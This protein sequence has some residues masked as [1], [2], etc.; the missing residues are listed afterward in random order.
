MTLDTD[1]L[2][3]GAG[4][5]GLSAACVLRKAGVDV[6]V[7]DAH[8]EGANTSRAAV[9]HART[10]EVLE[11]IDMSDELIREGLVVPEFTV[12]EKNRTLVRLDFSGLRTAYPYTL[13]IPQWRTEHLLQV[14]LG[15]LAGEVCW[16]TRLTA[17]PSRDG[18][19]VAEVRRE[20]GR[21]EQITARYV[22]GADGSHSSVR[23]EAGIPFRGNSYPAQFVLADITLRWPLSRTEVQLFFGRDGLVVVAP[24]PGGRHRIVATV[25]DAPE[26]PD[27][28]DVQQIL[29][30]RAPSGSVVEAMHW[31]SRFLVQH[32]LADRYR[33][34]NVFLVGD[35]AHV[36]SPAGGQGM[37]TGIQDALDLASRLVEVVAGRATDQSLD[38]YETRRRPVAA[39]VIRLTDRMTRAATVRAAPL[40]VGRN[41]LFRTAFKSP[42]LRHMLA[43]RIAELR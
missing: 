37:N 26:R 41:V 29:D 21:T 9:V 43:H 18:M 23:A 33:A 7:I 22:I 40:R 17:L 27:I 34:G 5:T 1:V 42:Q 38:E 20:D 24:L 32:R 13:M 39:G 19:R 36:H 25:H 16:K 14:R 30:A 6:V 8:S 12:R 31:S 15:E 11:A 35:A 28:A 4:P 2:I 3:V 10:L